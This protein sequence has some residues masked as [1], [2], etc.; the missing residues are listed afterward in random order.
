MLAVLGLSPEAL[1]RVVASQL[2]AEDN[3]DGIAVDARLQKPTTADK[4]HLPGMLALALVNGPTSCVVSGRPKALLALREALVQISA[5]ACHQDTSL[6][7]HQPST[8]A[9]FLRVSAPFHCDLNNKAAAATIA[10]A[11]RL[12]LTL[13]P[14][15]LNVPVFSTT[16]GADL[17]ASPEN[18]LVPLLVRMQALERMDF[19]RA[20]ARVRDGP[21]THVLDFGPGG[22]DGVG[23]A[24]SLTSE[25]GVDVAVV[26]LFLILFF[27]ECLHPSFLCVLQSSVY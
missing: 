27:C 25:L 7:Q 8:T 21:V 12:G 10:Q 6:R 26:G 22:R 14:S 9:T 4:G 18:D 24:A 3:R 17:R 16:D 5:P 13:P 2:A 19:P 1:E 15:A 23:G 20:L 11:R